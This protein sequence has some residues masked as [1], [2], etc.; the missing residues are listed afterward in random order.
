MSNLKY[1]FHPRTIAVIGASREPTKLGSLVLQN[2]VRGGFKG[3]IYPVNPHGDRILKLRCYPSVFDIPRLVDVAVIV[4]PSAAVSPVIDDCVR[5]K[6]KFAII[7][8]AGFAE[9]GQEGRFLQDQIIHKAERGG[10]RVLGP[11]CLGYISSLSRVNAHFGD[12]FKQPGNVAFISQSGALGTAI[13]DWAKQEGIGF[14]YF[15]SLGNKGD[16]NENDVLD[17]LANDSR[18][19]VVGCYLES[20]TNGRAFMDSVKRLTRTK[21]LIVLKAGKTEEARVA[22][23]SHTGALAGSDVAAR[24]AVSQC[25]G[26]YVD[27]M[28]DFF[29]LIKVFSYEPPPKGSDVAIV[30]NAGGPGVLTTDALVSS[31]LTLAALSADTTSRLR[32]LL[33][34]SA[35]LRNPVDIIGDALAERYEKALRV[36]LKDKKQDAVIVILTPQVN[37]EVERTAE[38][39]GKLAQESKKPILASFIGGERVAKGVEILNHYRVATFPFPE[40]AVRTLETMVSYLEKKFIVRSFD[41]RRSVSHHVKEQALSL[42]RT[43]STS[44]GWKLPDTVAFSIAALYGVPT[45]HPQEVT[46]LNQCLAVTQKTGF[47]VVLKVTSPNLFHRTE[48]GGVALGLTSRNEVVKAYTDLARNGR[49]VLVQKMVTSGVEV[50]I[51]GKK[52]PDFGSLVMFGT[53]GIY[54]EVYGDLAFGVSPLSSYDAHSIIRATKIYKVLMGARGVKY[55]IGGIAGTLVAVSQ[56]IEDLPLS[57]VDINP[58]IV[59]DSGYTAVDVKMKL[60]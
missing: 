31:G 10:V 18:I 14:G 11:N 34:A 27:T 5:K 7:I 28:Q 58:L 41:I 43:S 8:S 25:G 32:Q 2:L 42:I 3:K 35:S 30:T 54:T 48:K 22:V 21:P 26:I 29:S 40:N 55:D 6:V 44:S 56:M 9:T 17:F 12:V 13:L 45:T 36:V 1:L 20:F 37:T 46:S 33:P 19:E 15:V 52:D 57:E 23:T 51:G 47:P 4:V 16:I 59:T 60:V 38:L 50:I 49:T 39:I 53:G 24:A